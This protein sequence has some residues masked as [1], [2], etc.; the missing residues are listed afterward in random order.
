MGQY[1]RCGQIV[2]TVHTGARPHAMSVI[3]L[4]KVLCAKLC[5]NVNVKVDCRT[6]RGGHLG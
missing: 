6:G 1:G 3:L 2:C 4:W 5:G